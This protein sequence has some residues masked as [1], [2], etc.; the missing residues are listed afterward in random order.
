MD[1][2]HLEKTLLFKDTACGAKYKPQARDNAT[3]FGQAI[4]NMGADLGNM[5]FF[6][7]LKTVNSC[8]PTVTTSDG[9]DS[10]SS[11][12]AAPRSIAHNKKSK[13]RAT[14]APPIGGGGAGLY[15]DFMSYANDNDD[16]M[17]MPFSDENF[18]QAKCRKQTIPPP[19]MKR[20]KKMEFARRMAALQSY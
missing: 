7:D 18:V 8:N 19:A 2:A 4:S 11:P 9:E 3:S 13:N 6:D 17:T 15:A 5:L 12:V 20:F 14:A 16:D 10:Q 1:F